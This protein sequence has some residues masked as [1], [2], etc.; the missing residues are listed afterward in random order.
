[1]R[2]ATQAGENFK[3]SDYGEILFPGEGDHPEALQKEMKIKY[4]LKEISKPSNEAKEPKKDETPPPDFS[5]IEPMGG[6][7]KDISQEIKH[8]GRTIKKQT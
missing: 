1:M 3:P 5:N 2:S 6:L 7:N 4:G 8:L